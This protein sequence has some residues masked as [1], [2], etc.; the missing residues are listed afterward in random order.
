MMVQKTKNSASSTDTSAATATATATA[1]AGDPNACDPVMAHVLTAML[2]QLL[3]GQLA[4]A[5]NRGQVF[6]TSLTSV[7]LTRTP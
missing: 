3:D 6:E 7:R 1:Y 5:L 4:Q 2:K